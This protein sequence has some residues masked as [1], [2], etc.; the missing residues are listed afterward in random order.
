MSHINFQR[1]IF[2]WKFHLWSPTALFYK[3]FSPWS[4]TGQIFVEKKFFQITHDSMQ[5]F[6]LISNNIFI[7][8]YN[9]VMTMRIAKNLWFLLKNH[10]KLSKIN[11]Y[12]SNVSL[13]WTPF[14]TFFSN[15]FLPFCRGEKVVQHIINSVWRLMKW[16][17]GSWYT[18]KHWP[19]FHSKMSNHGQYLANNSE[20]V[21]WNITCK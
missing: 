5:F 3:N 4:P 7:F 14:D 12:E 16:L 2:R 13:V 17:N 9:C 18:E 21:Y 11:K 15:I 20:S 6:M 19:I 8:V 1:K 10:Q